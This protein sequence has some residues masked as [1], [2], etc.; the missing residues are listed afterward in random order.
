MARLKAP[1]EAKNS[2]SHL[3][4]RME[5]LHRV[6]LYLQASATTKNISTPN[7]TNDTDLPDN[8]TVNETEN[9]AGDLDQPQTKAS[10]LNLSRVCV[11]QMRGVS[12]KTQTRLPVPVKRSFCKRCDSL[13]IPGVS[14]IHETQ[15]PSRGGKKAWAELLVVRCFTCGTEKRFP[16]T[17]RR[18]EKLVTRQKEKQTQQLAAA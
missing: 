7:T 5:Y 6:S 2:K 15:N 18:S 3:K 14:C 11:S 12:L 1:K 10:L 13:L 8:P 17:D 16:Q 4:A 9:L